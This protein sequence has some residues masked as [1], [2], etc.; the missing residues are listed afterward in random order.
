MCLNICLNMVKTITIRTSVY[1]ELAKRKKPGESFSEY[2]M[3]LLNQ[4]R[5]IDVLE[6]LRGTLEFKNK[7]EKTR[8][9]EEIREKRH[10]RR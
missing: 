2:F 1:V 5:P 10:E 6:K 4:G 7:E 9:L 8:M 3:R